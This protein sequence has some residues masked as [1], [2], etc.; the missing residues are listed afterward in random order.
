MGRSPS[1][2]A[3]WMI[4][5]AASHGWHLPRVTPGSAWP[6][7]PGNR[8]QV[9]PA[10]WGRCGT[11]L[12]PASSCAGLGFVHACDIGTWSTWKQNDRKMKSQNLSHAIESVCVW[13]LFHV[14]THNELPWANSHRIRC[15]DKSTRNLIHFKWAQCILAAPVHAARGLTQPDAMLWWPITSPGYYC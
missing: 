9:R 3:A 12:R 13:I 11:N 10:V 7:H 6:F 14:S 4:W 1:R 15:F 8:C 5:R 2:A